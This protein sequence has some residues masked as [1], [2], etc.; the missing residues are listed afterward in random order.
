MRAGGDEKMNKI[1]EIFRRGF[2]E[3]LLRNV[4]VVVCEEGGG[5]GEEG[6]GSWSVSIPTR[7][8]GRIVDRGSFRSTIV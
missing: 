4:P 1:E 5:G 3:R 7:C 2:H 6:T 8:F